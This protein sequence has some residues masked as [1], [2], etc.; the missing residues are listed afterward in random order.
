M[1][2]DGTEEASRER[3]PSMD[4][5]GLS[6]RLSDVRDESCERGSSSYSSLTLLPW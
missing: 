2:S 5:I 4:A 6:E 1:R 3:Y